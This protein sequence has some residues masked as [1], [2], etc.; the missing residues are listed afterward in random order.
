MS[1][2]P[3]VAIVA[4]ALLLP[5]QASQRGGPEEISADEQT[6]TAA[7]LATDGAALLA[8]FNSRTRLDADREHLMGLTQQLGDPSV[9]VQARAAAELVARGTAAVPAL[10]HAIND[11]SDP[12]I[13]E[14]ARR[15][16]RTIEGAP[17]AAIPAAAARV[18]ATRKPAGAAEALLS[19]LPY[20]DDAS[21]TEAVS[22]A[23]AAL[24]YADGKPNAAI[25]KALEDPVPVR[26]AVA[27]EALCRKDQPQ[28][29]PAIRKLLHDPKPSVRLRAALVLANQQD[30]ASIPVLIDLLAELSAE[31]RKQAEEVLQSV[32]GEWA[33]NVNLS[34]D[35]DVSRRIRRDAWKAWWRNTDGNALLAELHKH[36]L[37]P[38]GQDKIESLIRNLGDD[39]FAVREQAVT[40]L[41][42]HG[43]LALPFLRAA[44]K[45]AD[46]ERSRRAESCL[47]LI[48]RGASKP[49]PSAAPRLLVLRRPA[50][51]IEALLAYLPYAENDALS[52]EVQSALASLALEDG[53][54]SAAL[55]RALEDKLPVRRAAAAGA[56]AQAGGDSFR[57][58]VHKLLQDPEPSVRVQVALALAAAQDK[59]AVPVL[60]EALADL[61]SELTG[62]VH[63]TLSLLAGDAA[64]KV[65]PGAEPDERRQCR[66]AWAAWWKEHAASVDFRRLQTTERLLGYT[67]L[68]EVASNGV[69]RVVEMDR[70]GRVRWCIDQLQYPVD[71]WVVG[72]DRVLIAEYN[73]MRVSERDFKGKVLWE[74]TGLRSQATN[75]QRLANGNTF[76]ATMRDV[77]EVDRTGR[78]IMRTTFAGR[79]SFIAAYKARDGEIVALTG[80]GTCIRMNATGKE[81]KSFPAG[82]DG[83]WTSGLDLVP[84]GRILVSQPN[85]NRVQ[86]FDRDGKVLW[87]KPAPGLVTASWLPNGHVLVASYANQNVVELDRDGRT[88]WQHKSDYHVFRV[89]RR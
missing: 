86:L 43:N 27:C 80:Q 5:A 13:A 10:R 31:Q 49:L 73:G 53:K 32:A 16:L 88:V 68:V 75:V 12:Q 36:T 11:L 87:E 17:G 24:A 41:V 89:R 39:V 18:L 71:A 22:Q 37:T 66:D 38:E 60:I 15:C 84:D 3:S 62:H 72:S 46:L 28:Q 58:A 79:Q 44:T 56:L 25:V 6:L 78:E 59:D 57:P 55:V 70:A 54:P 42:A 29:W 81:I 50:G 7:G 14:R 2:V 19:Y 8:F 47:R 45:D 33:P 30:A 35:D 74:K 51:A 1:T 77:M 61:P 26:R 82:R 21:V 4:V 34:T 20:A 23:I 76:I 69:G 83:A 64:P 63:E 40:E 48:A 52:A 65:V 9:E 67:L 85:M